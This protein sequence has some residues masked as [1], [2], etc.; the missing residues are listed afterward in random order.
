MGKIPENFIPP[1]DTW[2]EY[3]V[4]E[5]FANI[6]AELNIA[7]FLID[8]HV[9]EGRGD[10]PAI[11][12]M[13]KTISY[14]QLQ[15]MVNKFGNA[16]KESGVEA[17]DRVG[18]RLVNSPQA[19]VAVFAIEKIGAI[20]VPTSPLWSG[21]E[22]AFVAN[23]AEMRYFIV[24]APLMDA[25]AKAK[26]D[27]KHGTKVIVIGGKPDEVKA[28]GDQVFEEMLEKG[29]PNLDPTM[30]KA[31]D[32]GIILYT[33]GTTGMPKGCIHFVRPVIIEA[34]IVNKYVYKLAPGD[35]LGG[36]APV[37]FAAGFGTF[38]LLPFEGGA[39]I[40][41]IPK[42]T[43]QDMMELISKHKITVMTG[44][45]TAYRGLMKFPDF[46][47]YDVSSIRM[48]T[49]GGDALGSE[50]L[51]AWTALT[52]KPIWEG[53]G[54]TEMLHLVTSNTMNPEPVPNSIGK[55]L[56]GVLVRVVDAEGKDCKP[57]DIGSM[58]L[59]G[60]SGSLYWKPYED[61]EKLLKSQK[62]GVVNGWNQMGDAVFM[63]E[64]GNI[65]FVS[66]EDD[67]IKSSGY[68][69]GPAEVEEAIAKHPAIADVGVVGVP[70]PDKGQI[71]KAVIVCKPGFEGGD[72]LSDEL[73][74][75]LKEHIAIYKL[76]RVFE[77]V[78]EL[79]RTPTGKL[80]R[81]KLR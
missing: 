42:F 78:S 58:L 24:N 60:A 1:R 2:P 31:D 74:E 26:P 21:E 80:L 47:K 54:G 37:S 81:R 55:A 48:Y 46:K 35:T 65:F 71:T 16:L 28:G 73:K 43:P 4:P 40:S 32:V 29:S 18:I 62:K 68:R 52:G 79:P 59:K 45:P 49:S 53:L 56:P 8:R 76:P 67:M 66:R 7:E 44:L 11:K 69:I 3:I 30:L 20:P 22:V 27:F 36:A 5:E 57:G 77:Y 6:P 9:R 10:N 50:T 33:S 38:T 14:A 12:F 19:I 61:N 13:D 41:L 17:Q 75:F 51:D 15:Q 25:V 64:D 72:K 70:D 63:N 23:N 34:Q 39:A